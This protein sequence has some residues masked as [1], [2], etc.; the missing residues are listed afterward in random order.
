MQLDALTLAALV[1]ELRATQAG[2]RV[3]EVIQP[4]PQAV[5][6]QLYAGGAKRWLLI[7]AHPQLARIQLVEAK[8]RKLVAEPPAFV[9]LLRKHLEG[10][11]L[12][13]VRQPPAERLVELGFRISGQAEPTWLVAELTGRLSNVI[14]RDAG[15]T[16]L[17]AL[18]PVGPAVN[19]YRAIVPNAPYVAPPP[20]T[21]TLGGETL[22]RLAGAEVTAEALRV[23]ANEL[24]ATADREPTPPVEGAKRQRRQRKPAAPTLR[25][26]LTTQVAGFGPEL[27]EEASARALG[28]ADAPLD[29]ELEWEALA[30]AVRDLAA[31]ETTR[32][33]RP[34]LVYA[35]DY[36]SPGERPVAYAVYEPRR[37]AGTAGLRPVASVSVMLAAYYEDAE[38]R[39][40]M[41]GAKADVQQALRTHVERVR[42]KDDVLRGELAALD[43]ASRLRVEADT[44]RAFQMEVPV[45]AAEWRVANP[46]GEAGD[47]ER[48]L[49]I[50]LDP[51]LSPLENATK[52]YERYHKLQRAAS[53]IPAQIEANAT[54]RARLE[55][56]AADLALTETPAEVAV[57][58]AEVAEA[59]YLGRRAASAAGAKGGK[60][61]KGGKAGK[62]GKAKGKGPTQPREPGGAPLR[63]VSSDGF[64]LLVGK[65]SRQNE[66]VTFG[67]GRPNDVWLHA[68]GVPGAHVVVRSG[69]RPVPETTL[70]EAAALAAYYSQSRLEGSVPVDHTEVRYV[71]HMKGGGPGMVIYERE[72][73]LHVAPAKL[74]GLEHIREGHRTR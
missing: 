13:E 65:N 45:G 31:L 8:P 18:K 61:G 50:A 42:R 25:T 58:R 71:R 57:V 70:R 62:P 3:E 49:I 10:A 19:R 72:R 59:G 43:E 48:P 38:W 2:A 74:D 24:L 11:R 36:T 1:D 33:W 56:L 6:L 23:A 47:G 63:Y 4:T 7:S 64:V 39:A 40:A 68:R 54:E 21:R 32:A 14:V 69:G 73:T 9:M 52:K 5:A 53:Q 20:Q 66:A 55:Q 37:F 44:L 12:V 16:I 60:S 26:L 29:E 27:A 51:R 30:A 67:E 22:P 34:T 15:G 28:V 17:G 41:E 46:F 35:Q